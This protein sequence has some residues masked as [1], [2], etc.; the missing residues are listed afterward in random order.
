LTKKIY[1]FTLKLKMYSYHSLD[2]FT[3]VSWC[4]H[5]KFETSN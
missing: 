1:Q 4:N 5:F 2:L 3:K